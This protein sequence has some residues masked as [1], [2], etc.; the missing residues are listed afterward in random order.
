[1]NRE[2]LPVCF[3]PTVLHNA[4]YMPAIARVNA[5]RLHNTPK[6]RSNL[7]RAIIR[8]SSFVPVILIF[9]KVTGKSK[10]FGPALPGFR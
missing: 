10:R 7:Y 1:M 9:A 4:R 5:L 8:G 3:H 2:S 6:L